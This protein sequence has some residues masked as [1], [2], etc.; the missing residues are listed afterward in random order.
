MFEML[1]NRGIKQNKFKNWVK[2]K[3]R[4]YKFYFKRYC[5]KKNDKFEKI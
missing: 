2:K 3:V 4:I 1:E 5:Y